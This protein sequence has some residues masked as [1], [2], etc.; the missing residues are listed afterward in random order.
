MGQLETEPLPSP[1]RSSNRFLTESTT[2]A[3]LLLLQAA[4]E[5]VY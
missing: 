2:Q 4:L 5:W 1:P 3:S